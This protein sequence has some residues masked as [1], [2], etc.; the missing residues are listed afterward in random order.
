MRYLRGTSPEVPAMSTEDLRQLLSQ[1]H[2][3]LR[4][5]SSLDAQARSLLTTLMHDIERALDRKSATAPHAAPR[6]ES[7]AVQFEADHPAIAGTLREL[8]DAL[9]KA[10]I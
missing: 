1:V 8:V 3:R 5:T 6:L 2:E 10:G 4:T 9:V 7:L